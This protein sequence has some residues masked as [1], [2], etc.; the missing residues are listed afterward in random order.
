MY[1][2]FYMICNTGLKWFN[3]ESQKGESENGFFKKT[4]HAKFSEKRRFLTLWSTGPYLSVFSLNAKNSYQK[5]SE[6]G[7][8]SRSDTFCFMKWYHHY[9]LSEKIYSKLIVKKF[10]GS[11]LQT[12]YV[13]STLKHGVFV[14]F[15]IIFSYSVLHSLLD[16]LKI[17]R[18][19]IILLI[20]IFTTAN[21]WLSTKTW[22]SSPNI[23][24]N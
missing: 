24:L 11:S 4:K 22:E 13:D 19:I 8:F 12:H 14:G 20:S 2:F 16:G 23:K 18:Y 21:E 15:K 9:I 7:H 10:A 3:T 17:W 6:Y 5:I 1:L